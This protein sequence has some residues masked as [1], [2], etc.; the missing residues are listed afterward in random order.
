MYITALD[1]GT[2]QIKVSVAEIQK[3]GKLSL[4]SVFKMPSVGLRKGEIISLEEAVKSLHRV[5]NE[6]K[7]IN[8]AAAKNIF[9]NVGGG[10]IKIQNSRGI[11]A[12]SRADNEIYSDDID[13]AISA[14]Q[15]INLG[16]NRMIL[17]SITRE[18]VVDG[19]G[20]ISDPL[21]MTGSRLEVNSLIIDAFKPTVNN[22]IKAV[23]LAGGKIGGLIYSPLAVGRSVLTKAQKELGA[24]VIDIGFGATSMASYEEGKLIQ[25]AVFPVGASNITNDLA[26]GL[27]CPIKIAETIKLS[28]GSAMAREVSSKEKIDL[29]QIDESL[30]SIINKH[31]IAEIIE[32]RLAEIFEFVNNELK[33]IGKLGKLPAGA[34][35]AG[36]GAKM[37]HIIELAKQELKLSAQLGIPELSDI[38]FTNSEFEAQ[39]GDSEFSVCVGLLL[40]GADQ[41]LKENGWSMTKKGLFS[42]ILKHFLP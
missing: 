41:S 9:I 29:H 37:P 38:E 39:L 25:A 3:D 24:V 23:E 32:V 1:L 11:V 28:F 22:L 40:W 27:K 16:P 33:F 5:I 17:H 19:I 34:M 15:A 10:N 4:L 21:G 30:K 13:R 35:I 18:F 31:F 8:K 26:I 20:E 36:A 12:V 7:Q 42:K 14:S 6:I 2:S